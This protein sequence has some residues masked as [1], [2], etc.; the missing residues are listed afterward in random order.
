M[1]SIISSIAYEYGIVINEEIC[2]NIINKYENL[3]KYMYNDNI[4]LFIKCELGIIKDSDKGGIY[5]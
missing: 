5:G 1:I 4:E 3:K 2:N